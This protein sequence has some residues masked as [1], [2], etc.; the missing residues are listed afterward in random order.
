MLGCEGGEMLLVVW[1]ERGR[2]SLGLIVIVIVMNSDDSF[3]Q[4]LTGRIFPSISK[5]ITTAAE[6]FSQKGTVYHHIF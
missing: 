4:F 3:G 6:C 2:W 5:H 1:E